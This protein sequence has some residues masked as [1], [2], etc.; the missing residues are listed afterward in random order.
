MKENKTFFLNGPWGSG[1]TEFLNTVRNQVKGKKFTLRSQAKGK[2]FIYLNLWELKDERT[3]I[4]IGINQ[5]FHG[6]Y[7]FLKIF[8]IFCVAISILSTPAIN[9]GLEGLLSNKLIKLAGIIGLLVAVVQFFK[10]KSDQVF[11]SILNCRRVDKLLKDKVLIVDDF[12]RVSIDKQN[13]AYKLFNI[14]HNRLPIIFVGDINKL[15]IDE[16]NYLQKIID[17]RID[18]PY[19]LHSQGIWNTYFKR[20]EEKFNISLPEELLKLFIMENRNLRDRVQFND[21]VNQEFFLHAKKDHVQCGQQL[22]VIYIYLFHYK[23]YSILLKNGF[24][25]SEGEE[26][27]TIFDNLLRDNDEYPVSFAK[28]RELYFISESVNNMTKKEIETILNDSTTLNENILEKGNYNDDLYHYIL[29]KYD[30]IESE[31]QDDLFNG[32]IVNALNNKYSDLTKLIISFKKEKIRNDSIKKEKTDVEKRIFE[33]WAQLLIIYGFDFSQQ[34]K[35]I[36]TNSILSFN[37]LSEINPDIDIFSKDYGEQKEKL[38]YLLTYLSKCNLWCKFD[39]WS[40][41]LWSK[42]EELYSI[43]PD[44]FLL[45]LRYNGLIEIPGSEIDFFEKNE[46]VKHYVVYEKLGPHDEPVRGIRDRTDTINKIKPKL[47]ELDSLGYR[48]E[49]VEEKPSNL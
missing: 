34:L 16:D 40:E 7:T 27:D 42:I 5:I 12:D 4:H 28:N 24:L 1:K 32:A 44:D 33:E 35:F 21:Y 18:L 43:N 13:E 47:D 31:T 9:L 17:K 8:F 20:L 49:Y 48:F 19:V 23:K 14:L 36:Q 30:D 3:V 2:K 15:A 45:Y 25:S 29:K 11:Y 22:L 38:Y 39:Q 26:I 41:D 46:L 37:A 10:V 6:L